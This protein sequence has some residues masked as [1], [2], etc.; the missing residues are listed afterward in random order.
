[1]EGGQRVITIKGSLSGWEENSILPCE[2][3]VLLHGVKVFKLC[4]VDCH[5]CLQHLG[6][7][8]VHHHHKNQHLL[9]YLALASLLT[10]ALTF[11]VTSTD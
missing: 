1:M 11:T 8:T 6:R 5:H 7:M 10:L 2:I 9:W 4:D 3:V